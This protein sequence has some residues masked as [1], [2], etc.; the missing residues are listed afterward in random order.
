[1]VM[2]VAEL[3]LVELCEVIAPQQSG[4][5][6]IGRAQKKP[7]SDEKSGKMSSADVVKITLACDSRIVTPQVASTFLDSLSRF[8]TQPQ[9]LM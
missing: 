5:L 6:T 8:I 2:N 4:V 1:M 7:V 3:G 9:L